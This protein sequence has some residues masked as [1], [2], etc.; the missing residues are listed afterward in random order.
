MKRCRIYVVGMEGGKGGGGYVMI[1]PGMAA[2][3]HRAGN[4]D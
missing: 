1:S 4:D 3:R 2:E